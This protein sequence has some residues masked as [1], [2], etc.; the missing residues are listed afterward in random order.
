MNVYHFSYS[1]PGYNSGHLPSAVDFFFASNDLLAAMER[2]EEYSNG[3]EHDNLWIYDTTM[4]EQIAKD[5]AHFV[6]YNQDDAQEADD[7]MVS[8][9][10]KCPSIADATLIL[11]ASQYRTP[12]ALRMLLKLLPDKKISSRVLLQSVAHNNDESVRILVDSGRIKDHDGS[13]LVHTC[14]IGKRD[15]FDAVLPVSNLEAAMHIASKHNFQWLEEAFACQQNKR[16]HS[17]L[18]NTIKDRSRK[19]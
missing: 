10:M 19:I 4:D 15:L 6:Y 18:P 13:V 17:E 1:H 8:V 2:F 14:E 3:M 5:A 9:L 16:L 11:E 7:L 12:N